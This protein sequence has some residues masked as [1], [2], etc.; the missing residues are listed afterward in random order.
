MNCNAA[1]DVETARR[2][3]KS[4]KRTKQAKADEDVV[5]EVKAKVR[6]ICHLTGTI[7]SALVILAIYVGFIGFV[8]LSIASLVFRTQCHGLGPILNP[9][10]VERPVLKS[11]DFQ[12]WAYKEVLRYM[13]IGSLYPLTSPVLAK[14]L[15]DDGILDSHFQ[16]RV[17][18]AE[19]KQRWTDLEEDG[20]PNQC[21]IIM[22][23]DSAIWARYGAMFISFMV[24]SYFMRF[25]KA[26]FYTAAACW[27][28]IATV[29]KKKE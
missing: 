24:L 13:S 1:E 28:C 29:Y 27:D 7:I 5:K 15:Q 22:G 19:P 3:G 12:T 8:S 25:L 23:P 6:W 9:V 20:T 18:A 17:I 14:K 4:L 10:I 16:E 26:V 11:D 21:S 2:R